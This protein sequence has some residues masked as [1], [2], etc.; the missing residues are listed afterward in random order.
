MSGEPV[1]PAASLT[2]RANAVDVCRSSVWLAS[3][4]E[5]RDVPSDQ[6]LR[7]DLCL[8]EALANVINHGGPGAL[9]SPVLLRLCVERYAEHNAAV[10]WITD[11]GTAFDLEDYVP[12]PTPDSLLAAQP[13]GLGLKMMRAF[14]DDLDYCRFQ[15]RNE[16]R[17]T[18]HWPHSA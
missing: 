12:R 14:S 2:I 15:D 6:I 17:I 11:S 16:L 7:L 10:L 3:E 18:I 9:R 13:G 1:L 5:E 4:C 8:N